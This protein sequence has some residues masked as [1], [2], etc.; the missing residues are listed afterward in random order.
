M[1]RILLCLPSSHL[2]CECKGPDRS[3][4]H[5]R[6]LFRQNPLKVRLSTSHMSRSWRRLLGENVGT[7]NRISFPGPIHPGYNGHVWMVMRA[8]EFHKDNA[9]R[10]RSTKIQ[11]FLAGILENNQG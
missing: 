2:H 11:Y 1:I 9:N 8:R 5:L 7:L 4:C 3:P 6:N 10:H